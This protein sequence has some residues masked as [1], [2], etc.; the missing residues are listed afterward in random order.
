M[1]DP[2]AKRR[3]FIAW[4]VCIAAGFCLLALRAWLLGAAAWTVALRGVIAAG[5]ALLA[6]EQ[7]RRLSG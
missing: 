5:F 6:W 4:Y 7:W 1:A 2:R 3:L